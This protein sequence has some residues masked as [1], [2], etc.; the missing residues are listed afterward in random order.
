M[1]GFTRLS[2]KYGASGLSLSG[3]A[4]LE[5]A[6]IGGQ[7]M[8]YAAGATDYSAG[9]FRVGGSGYLSQQDQFVYSSSSGTLGVHGL[10]IVEA[11]SKHAMIPHATFED[12][13]AIHE[14]HGDGRFDTVSPANGQVATEMA[15]L[16]ASTSIELNGEVIAYFANNQNGGFKG[17]Q[18]D[19]SFNLSEITTRNDNAKSHLGDI[20]DLIALSAYGKS[21]IFATSAEDAGVSSYRLDKFGQTYSKHNT[22][23]E[24]GI[25]M[26]APSA[27]VSVNAG[28][29]VFLI[30]AGSGSSSLTSFRISKQG[31]LRGK[32]H[33]VDDLNTRF[34]N[35]TA[36]EAVQID[37]RSFVVAGGADDGITLFEITPRSGKLKL[38]GILEDSDSLRLEDVSDIEALEVNGTLH[39]YVTSATE[40]G[41]SHLR[42]EVGNLGAP[43]VGTKNDEVFNGTS[44]DD[45]ILGMNGND[46]LRGNAGND[47]LI[48]G[49]G[50]DILEGGAGADVFV[51]SIDRKSD[52]IA[53]FT[54][55]EDK[56]DLSEI[57]MLYG[58]DQLELFEKDF[59]TIVAFGSE[60]VRV[61][62][63]DLGGDIS[64]ND[65]SADDFLFF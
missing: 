48:D 59:G 13:L 26:N 51:F 60:R 15:R 4:D 30:V 14:L 62:S 29:D 8:L 11:G 34:S 19:S 21:F 50:T 56:I 6:E 20:T 32:D 58:I 57:P 61:L 39:F 44:K 3:V 49:R 28:G 53:D 65:L 38:W 55:G 64:P 12:N 52:T 54:P 36:L 16:T 37:G 33:I 5:L 31:V 27:M 41:I 9:V 46:T 47:W 43:I 1:I 2:T 40:N 23:P 24:D 42:A 22:G 10:W 35:V 25:G 18:L 45:L 63:N 17:Y 7:W